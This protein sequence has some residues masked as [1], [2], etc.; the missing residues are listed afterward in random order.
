MRWGSKNCV[1]DSGKWGVRPQRV[2]A[3]FQL[4]TKDLFL[5]DFN[6]SRNLILAPNSKMIHFGYMYSV[7]VVFVVFNFFFFFAHSVLCTITES[8]GKKTLGFS[9]NKEMCK[10]CSKIYVWGFLLLLFLVLFLFLV[11]WFIL[12]TKRAKQNQIFWLVLN[13][14][15]PHPIIFILA[16][17]NVILW[18]VF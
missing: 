7:G 5:Q 11:G 15:P 18:E 8:L 12:K 16:F 1:A 10:F 14:K 3:V 6:N 2:I 4:S 13:K 17:Y 9:C